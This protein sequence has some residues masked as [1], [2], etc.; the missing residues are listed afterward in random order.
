MQ[1]T[2]RY[3]GFMDKPQTPRTRREEYA[4]QTRQALLGAASEIFTAEGYQQAGIEAIAQSAR[5]TRGAFYHHFE[6]KRA[7]FE[8]LVISLQ[9][10][11]ADSIRRSAHAE[12]DANARVMAGAAAF[13]ESCTEPAYRRLVIQEAPAVLG[14]RRCREIGEAHP[15]GLLIAAVAELKK[16]GRFEVANTYLAARMIGSMICE[17][18]L[19]LDGAESPKLLKRQALAIVER[20]FDAFSTAPVRNVA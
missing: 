12:P 14:A 9:E 17:T 10:A 4:D 6:D 13:L 7:L 16:S 2:T 3:A 1:N 19:L 11:A 18:A 8:A 15:Y 20:V 5:V